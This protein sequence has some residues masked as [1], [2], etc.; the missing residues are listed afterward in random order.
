MKKI[1][2]GISSCLL[3]EN[4]RYDGGHRLDA[5][6]T[7]T[8]GKYFEFHPFCPEMGI[9]L[10][11]PRPTLHLVKI[12]HAIHCVGIKNPDWD[13]TEPL[14]GY[15]EQQKHL[16]A[17]LCGYILK[18][19]SPSCGMERVKVY[20]NNQPHADGVGIYAAEM[21]RNNPLLP[22]EEEGRLG[23][24]GLRENFIQ[25]VYVLYR[26]KEMLAKEL[27]ASRL[28]KFHA[29]HKLIIMSHEDYRDLGQL[30]AGL[31]KDN[32]VQVA[33]QYIL[34][35]MN[36]LK[37]PATRKNHVN[38]LQHIQGYLKK[39]LSSDDKAEL[40]EVIERYRNGYIPLI[41]PITLLKHHF[42][43]S[44]DPYIE[45]SYYMSPYPQELQLI[46]QL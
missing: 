9:G 18:K 44:P 5:Y 19:S 13:V 41:V 6:I 32:L 28:T 27:T 23:D 33:E 26:W 15:A 42:R 29:R 20:T 10:G 30:L 24:P 45:E 38:V 12:N 2:I 39:D 35:L 1:P 22:V 11:A 36:T 14:R 8:L 46:N 17:D 7:G 25:R 40:C 43:K 31:S 16:H 4:V 21:M 34:Q 37:K 3:G